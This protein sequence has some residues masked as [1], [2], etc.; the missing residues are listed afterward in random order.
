MEPYGVYIH[1]RVLEKSPRRGRQ[2]DQIE[3]F[4]R[5]LA[6]NPYQKGDYVDHDPVGHEIQIC[7]V[8][9]YAVHFWTDHPVKEVKVIDLQHADRA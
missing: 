6:E 4:F 3:A 9:K 1:Q 5:S 2:R 8:G 7:I